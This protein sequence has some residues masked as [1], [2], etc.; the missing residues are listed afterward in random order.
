MKINTQY[1]KRGFELWRKVKDHTELMHILH[2]RLIFSCVFSITI[3][4]AIILKMY[5][6]IFETSNNVINNT[7][8][9]LINTK[10]A[11]IVDRNGAVL[12][13][14][15]VTAS[16]YVNPSAVLNAKKTS[17]ILAKLEFLPSEN[18]IYNKIKD[19]KKQ[20]VWIK[21]HVTP[22]QQQKIMDLGLPGVA[23]IKDY[24]RVYPYDNLFSHILGFVDIDGNGI[25]GLEMRFDNIMRK[26]PNKQ[27]KLTL[28][29]RIQSILHNELSNAI[30]KYKAIAANG[31]IMDYSG[32]IIAIVSLP[33]FNPNKPLQEYE[34]KNFFNR[35]TLGVYEPGSVFK[36]LNIAIAL[37]TKT[38]DLNSKYDVTAPVKLGRFTINDFRGKNRI[39]N[40]VESFIYSSNIASVKI[41]QQFG[42][43]IQKHYM[44]LLGL[45]DKTELELPETG[46]SIFP[47]RWTDASA[48]TISYGYGISVTPLQLLTAVTSI[49]NG[50]FRIHP[51]LLF[52][53]TSHIPARIISENTS[54]LVHGLMRAVMLYGTG[55]TANIQS[56]GVIGKTGTSYKTVNGTYGKEGSRAR[57]TT[58]IGGFGRYMLVVMLDDPK[59]IDGTFGFATAA[60]NAVPTA[61]CIF[62]RIIPILCTENDLANQQ[63]T[64]LIKYIK[65]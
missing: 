41:F 8:Y 32:N 34:S 47:K 1:I 25:S 36:I 65:K 54:H 39:L 3:F 49:V 35:N 33:D 46:K 15:I 7:T 40:F 62:E 61:K 18:I 14:S 9:N 64:L 44:K 57:I 2:D 29:L 60:W 38:A 4:C 5:F 26:K 28:D 21:R 51:T 48:T 56:I 63:D 24:K 30:I 11:D 53:N 59:P 20:F 23:F 58:F 12:A 31:I 43:D 16:C 22:E 52:N 10:R 6:I 50:G 17:S 37:E 55:R 13:S 19:P 27:I 42:K 45:L